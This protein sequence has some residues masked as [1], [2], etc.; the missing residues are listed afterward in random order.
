MKGTL[1]ALVTAS[2]MTAGCATLGTTM[3]EMAG[4]GTLTVERAEFDNVTTVRMT[5]TYMGFADGGMGATGLGY[6]WRS[7]LPDSVLMTVKDPLSETFISFRSVSVNADGNIRKFNVGAN[8]Y[9]VTGSVRTG[10]FSDTEASFLVPLDFL[11]SMG[12]AEKCLIRITTDDGYIDHDF[13]PATRMGAATPKGLLPEFL[14]AVERVRTAA[15]TS[16]K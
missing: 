8:R 4:L 2:V 16:S 13:T 9:D 5:P 6:Q 3:N 7:D 12:K 1:L 10:F 11:V 15:E 14:A